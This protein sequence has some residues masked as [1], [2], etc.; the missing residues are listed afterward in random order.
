MKSSP[1]GI[2]T[3]AG[4]T[5]WRTPSRVGA[6]AEMEVAH[7]LIQ[8]GKSVYVPLFSPDS[9]VDLVVED[10]LGMRRVQCKT[11]ILNGAV[12]SFRTSSNTSN[13]PRGYQGEIDVFG[14]YSPELHKV[15]IVPI[16]DVPSR[17]AHL[18]LFPALNGQRKRLRWANDYVING[19][20]DA[21]PRQ[22]DPGPARPPA[23]LWGSRHGA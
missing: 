16:A 18:R 14:V 8:A 11:S 20:L 6:R 2:I 3:Y 22:P 13:I 21:P 5:I 10:D 1:D 15:F 12:I 7:A 4:G 23:S 9:R 17:L 19:P